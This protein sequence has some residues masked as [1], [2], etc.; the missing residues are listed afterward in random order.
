MEENDLMHHYF[1][2]DFLKISYTYYSFSLFL[3]RKKWL[4]LKMWGFLYTAEKINLMQ[5]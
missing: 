5:K 3:K 1:I 4:L 2:W